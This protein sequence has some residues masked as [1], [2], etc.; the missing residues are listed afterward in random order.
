MTAGGQHAPHETS[1]QGID[2]WSIRHKYIV[3]VDNVITQ[4]NATFRYNSVSRKVKL[5]RRTV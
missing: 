4:D 1:M 2:F 3:F 5:S